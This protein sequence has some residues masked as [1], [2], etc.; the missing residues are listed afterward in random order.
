MFYQA[1]WQDPTDEDEQRLFDRDMRTLKALG[2]DDTGAFEADRPPGLRSS[3]INYISEETIRLASDL[4]LQVGDAVEYTG[5]MEEACDCDGNGIDWDSTTLVVMNH[6]EYTTLMRRVRDDITLTRNKKIIK[7]RM[8]AIWNNTPIILTSSEEK[9][10]CVVVVGPKGA[11]KWVPR[12]QVYK[13]R[14]V[15]ATTEE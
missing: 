1:W 15:Y 5:H 7:A 6:R 8:A 9:E 10:G 14:P 2:M 12:I 3:L 4:N 11:H 13:E